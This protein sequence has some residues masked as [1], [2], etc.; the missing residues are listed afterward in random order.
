MCANTSWAVVSPRLYLEGHGTGEEKGI[1]LG[2]DG[3]NEANE[4]NAKWDKRPE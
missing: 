2:I 4:T 3:V 1:F